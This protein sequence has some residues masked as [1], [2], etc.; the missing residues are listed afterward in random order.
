V[1]GGPSLP[2]RRSTRSMQR[3]GQRALSPPRRPSSS[4]RPAGHSQPN[5]VPLPGCPK[6]SGSGSPR[7]LE[8]PRALPS[9]GDMST[10]RPRR[11]RA[12]RRA[13]CSP[14]QYPNGQAPMI[15]KLTPGS[16]PPTGSSS[17]SSATSSAC[18][19]RRCPSNSPPSRRPAT[20]TSNDP[21]A[22]GA[23]ACTPG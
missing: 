6:S 7:R 18:R 11:A 13:S 12:C 14:A 1:L 2:K 20:S 5:A 8:R 16:W 22:A 3:A 19:T 10:R 9:R 21:S 4:Q 23:G 15:W 17:P